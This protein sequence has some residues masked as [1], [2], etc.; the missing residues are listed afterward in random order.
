MSL[1]RCSRRTWCSNVLFTNIVILFTR[2]LRNTLEHRYE[3]NMKSV[4]SILISCLHFRSC[5]TKKLQLY[6]LNHTGM[7]RSVA[8][9]LGVDMEV[10]SGHGWSWI[11]IIKNTNISYHK[12]LLPSR[13][14]LAYSIHFCI[15]G[16][17]RMS[18]NV[19]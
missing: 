19:E 4:R 10:S 2:M 14:F 9:R 15:L 12:R 7:I 3:R 8:K 18:F 17:S 1:Q 5:W 13:C 16:C 11:I 6:G